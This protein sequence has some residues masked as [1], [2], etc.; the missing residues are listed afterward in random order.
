MVKDCSILSQKRRGEKKEA[1]G[2]CSLRGVHQL[3]LGNHTANFLVI[4]T[5]KKE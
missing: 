3:C 2:I 4:L 5:E 1:T